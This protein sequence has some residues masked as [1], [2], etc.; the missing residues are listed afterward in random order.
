MATVVNLL[1]VAMVDVSKAR[2]YTVAEKRSGAKQ[3]G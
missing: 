1:E 2:V 3:K